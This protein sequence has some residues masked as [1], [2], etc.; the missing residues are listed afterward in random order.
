MREEIR[1]YNQKKISRILEELKKKRYNNVHYFETVGEAKQFIID[2]IAK[3]ETV[4]VGGSITLREDL[5]IV[6]ALRSNGIRVFD[7]WEDG[8]NREKRIELKRSHRAVDVFLSSANAVTEAGEIVNLDGG[9]NR[10]ASL[11]SGPKR[12]ILVA[13]VNKLV[14]TID[15]AIERTRNTAA[16]INAVRKSCKTPCVE[17]GCCLDCKA[18]DRI[19]AA[20]LILLKKPG[21]IDE[22]T[23]LLVNETLGY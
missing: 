6:K 11:C 16:P 14:R 13:G 10:V 18:E 12:V 23:V 17:R 4:G 20:L 7:H 2:H 19:C 22:F 1:S 3:D 9:G 21:D 8:G 5:G 15:E